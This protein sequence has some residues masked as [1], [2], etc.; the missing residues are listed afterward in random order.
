MILKDCPVR[1]PVRLTSVPLPRQNVLRM[2]EIGI[3]VGAEAVIVQKAAFGGLIVNIAG[4]RIAVDHKWAKKI[5]AQMIDKGNEAD[6]NDS[7]SGN[8][9]EVK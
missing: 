4:S 2:Q 3:R 1:V 6:Q 5:E 9:Q 7:I 8:Q